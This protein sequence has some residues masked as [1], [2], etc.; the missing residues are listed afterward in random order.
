[1]TEGRR[2]KKEGSKGEG[3]DNEAN[4]SGKIPKSCKAWDKPREPRERRKKGRQGI[5]W[6][7]AGVPGNNEIKPV[8]YSG[9]KRKLESGSGERYKRNW[10]RKNKL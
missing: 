9:R 7:A 3:A 4:L 2:G 5:G 10:P 6:L 8:N 1:M